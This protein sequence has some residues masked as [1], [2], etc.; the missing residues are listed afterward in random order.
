MPSTNKAIKTESEKMIFQELWAK[1]GKIN[2]TFMNIVVFINT[3]FCR[4]PPISPPQRGLLVGCGGTP[5]KISV[6][7]MKHINL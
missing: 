2:F 5:F 1:M 7:C 6:N 3:A 4:V